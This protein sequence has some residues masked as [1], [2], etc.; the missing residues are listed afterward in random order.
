MVAGAKILAEDTS[1]HMMMSV[2]MV[3]GVGAITVARDREG[4]AGL[5]VSEAFFALLLSLCCMLEPVEHR[6][7]H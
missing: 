5:L 7:K 3:C 2:V 4:R 6:R 1:R